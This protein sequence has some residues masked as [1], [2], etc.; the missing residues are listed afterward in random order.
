MERLDIKKHLRDPKY[1]NR[2]RDMEVALAWSALKK[3]LAETGQD[4]L[5]S[6]IKSVKIAE[7]SI[8][9]TTQKPV[10]NTELKAMREALFARIITSISHI[11]PAPE[12]IE[13][14][15]FR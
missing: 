6:Y 12:S 10:V 1:Y 8:I 4:R 13:R 14:L 15:T 3:T 5:F 2:D 9:I 7:K 11:H